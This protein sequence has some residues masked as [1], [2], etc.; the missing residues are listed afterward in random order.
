VEN[1]IACRADVGTYFGYNKEERTH[2]ERR[3]A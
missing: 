1:G 3:V 2:D